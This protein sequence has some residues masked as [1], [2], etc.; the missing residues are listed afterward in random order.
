MKTTLTVFFSL[1]L[2]FFAGCQNTPQSE[3]RASEM[4]RS[5]EAY[6]ESLNEGAGSINAPSDENPLGVE[7]QVD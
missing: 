5:T 2:L 3:A 4:D 6:Q 7:N 1:G